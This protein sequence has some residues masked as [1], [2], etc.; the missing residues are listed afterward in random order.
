MVV[1]RAAPGA[2]TI[3]APARPVAGSV[4]S[5]VFGIPVPVAISVPFP[6]VWAKRSISEP[7]A[8]VREKLVLS[9][10]SGVGEEAVEIWLMTVKRSIWI[11]SLLLP[12]TFGPSRRAKLVP[13]GLPVIL[14]GV[15]PSPMKPAGGAGA[16]ASHFRNG[17]TLVDVRTVPKLQAGGAMVQ[18]WSSVKLIVASAAATNVFTPNGWVS[19]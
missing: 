13:N 16:V 4:V 17:P 6:T 12:P 5:V 14:C 7:P 11:V 2:S 3:R 15:T 8:T 1:G 19:V 9:T 10:V 18:P